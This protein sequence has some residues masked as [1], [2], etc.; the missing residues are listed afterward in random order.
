MTNEKEILKH[1][2]LYYSGHPTISDE[3]YDKLEKDQETIIYDG[4]T[5][6]IKH[7]TKMLSL[8]KVYDRQELYTWKG[9]EDLVS[10]HKVDGVSCSLIYQKGLL[11]IGK[12][13][14]DGDFGR[15]ISN[16]VAF[17]PDIPQTGGIPDCE[18]RGE[19]YCS[20][21]NFSKLSARMVELG[22][23]KPNNLR[24]IVAGLLSRKEYTELCQYLSFFAFDIII[25]DIKNEWEKMNTLVSIM[26]MK[27]PRTIYHKDD[28]SIETTIEE[29]EI[30][31]EKG[32]YPIDG[33]VFSYAS[34]KRQEE[35]G[36]TAHHPRYRKA[37]K[38]RGDTKKTEIIDII[39]SVSRKGNI[40]PVAHVTPIY[41]SGA[42]ISKVS[43]H[44]YRI[45]RQ[46]R[47]KIGDEVEIIRSG[48]V[49]PKLVGVGKRSPE[50]FSVPSRC[51]DCHGSIAFR[52][53]H[54]YCPNIDCWG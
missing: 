42:C 18:V 40:I 51:P 22:L 52:G 50:A 19:I 13:R 34:I 29:A 26:K 24:N 46:K 2:H 27:T 44:N 54:L 35:I 33:L 12:T 41:V 17:I 20:K 21:E 38:F 31:M 36:C 37:F 14:G 32:G 43:L 6:N 23:N 9:D 53:C 10:S 49:I 8:S 28:K 4:Q 11:I 1:K 47:L 7:T 15:N 45:V 48:G 30:F 25:D 5:N 39:W 3:Q 16:K